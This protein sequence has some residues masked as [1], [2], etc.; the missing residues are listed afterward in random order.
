MLRSVS[1]TGLASAFLG[2]SVFASPLAFAKGEGGEKWIAVSNTAMSITGDI[3]IS[4]TTITMSTGSVLPIEAVKSDVPNLYSYT[5]A[6]DLK[7]IRDNTFCLPHTQNGYLVLNYNAKG[8]LEMDVFGGDYA[9][10]S[11]EKPKSKPGFCASYF[12]RKP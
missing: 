5:D 2:L 9:P 4:S 11:P 8:E 1:G 12:Y 7:L 6:D 10:D 3:V